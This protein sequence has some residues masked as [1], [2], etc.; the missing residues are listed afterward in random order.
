[1]ILVK[2]IKPEN[3]NGNKFK[4]DLNNI[5]GFFLHQMN[6]NSL[7][8]I[9]TIQIQEDFL[10]TPLSSVVRLYL[11]GVDSAVKESLA[12]QSQVYCAPLLAC[13]SRSELRTSGEV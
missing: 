13:P 10:M 8:F 3:G 1:M 2:N 4:E 9:C 12:R 6:R 11:F 7:H 5:G